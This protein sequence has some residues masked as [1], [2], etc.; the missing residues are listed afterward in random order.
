MPYTVLKVSKVEDRVEVAG[1]FPSEAEAKEFAVD[2]Q[3]NDLSN[4]NDYMVESPPSKSP[5]P[6]LLSL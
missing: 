3:V 4:A 2:K 6:K 1:E 5:P